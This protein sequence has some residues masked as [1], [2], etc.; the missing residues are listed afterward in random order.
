MDEATG[1][2]GT[3]FSVDVC[4]QWEQTFF[5]SPTP[6]TRKVSLRSAMVFGLGEGGVF[7]AFENVVGLGLGGTLGTGDQMVSWVHFQ[8]FT[9]SLQWILEHEELDGPINIA[10]PNPIPNRRFMQIFRKTLRKGIGLPAARWMLEVGAFFLQ[11]ETE[12]IL[13]SRWVL[14]EKLHDSGFNFL[15]PEWDVAL[16]AIV[17]GP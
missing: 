2:I 13:K 12:L 17:N 6:Q 1:E 11:T 3:G 7:R 9:R 10:S 4:K 15:Y 16:N 5:N 14:P 8:D